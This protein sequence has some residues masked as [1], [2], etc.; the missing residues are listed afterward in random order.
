MRSIDA[1]D[2]EEEKKGLRGFVSPLKTNCYVCRSFPNF[3]KLSK[4]GENVSSCSR[5]NC[6]AQ[7][8]HKRL[9]LRLYPSKVR[10][11]SCPAPCVPCKSCSSRARNRAT[12]RD[13]RH[14]FLS[15]RYPP[16]SSPFL[17]AGCPTSSL[18]RLLCRPRRG[19]SPLPSRSRRRSCSSC[20]RTSATSSPRRAWC[21]CPA[22][23]SR[24]RRRDACEPSMPRPTPRCTM[25]V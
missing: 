13:S 20:S 9:C 4:V 11:A 8:A 22:A 15:T 7:S 23:P 18:Q 19:G 16:I 14:C 24:V 5:V 25:R 6:R 3:R 2:E 1:A 21:V 10:A 12:I 17:S